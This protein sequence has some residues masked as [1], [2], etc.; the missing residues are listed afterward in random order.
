MKRR[1][2]LEVE[3]G[4]MTTPITPAN[5]QGA[6]HFPGRITTESLQ[7]AIERFIKDHHG[8]TWSDLF[9][10]HEAKTMAAATK[11]NPEQTSPEDELTELGRS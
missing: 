4:H 9:R 10:E 8:K 6:L 7:V 11:P 2:I 1:P 5:Q 3:G